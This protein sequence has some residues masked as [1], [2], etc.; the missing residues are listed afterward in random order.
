MAQKGSL[1]DPE[2]LRFDF[3]TLEAMTADQVNQVEAIVNQQIQSE[4]SVENAG[5]GI[6]DAMEKCVMALFGEKY[7]EKVH[8]AV[9]GRRFSV[10]LCGGTPCGPNWRYRPV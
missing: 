5:N 1:V 3:L 8:C 6:D 4:Y 9:H 10:E 2:R 7:G